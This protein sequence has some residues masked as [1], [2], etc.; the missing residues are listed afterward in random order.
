MKRARRYLIALIVLV[1]LGAI[2]FAHRYSPVQASHLTDKLIHSLHGPGFVVVALLI[3][4]AFRRHHRGPANYLQAGI[5]A[6]AI[7]VFSEAVQIPGPRDAQVADLIVDGVGIIGGL[8]IVALFDRDI[9]TMLRKRRRLML[10]VISTVALTASVASTLWYGYAI[11]EQSRAAPELLTF[12]HRWESAIFNKL[13]DQRPR[14]R[15]TPPGWPGSGD[16]V[17]YAEESGRWGILIRLYPYPDWRN[18]STLSFV[19]A[20]DSDISHDV[21]LSIQDI[22]PNKKDSS[23]RYS[24]RFE[25]GPNPMRYEFSLEKVRGSAQAHPFDISRIE[26]VRLS[27]SNPGSQITLLI[28]D[29]RLD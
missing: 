13:N 1:F 12:E 11:V 15:P 9:V 23:N 21:M 18:Y 20:S 26:S 6:M 22:R 16:A 24:E 25:V 10:A 14:L 3:L 5:A 4:A 17:G 7:G 27:A 29:F 8:G 19:A 2:A 28:D